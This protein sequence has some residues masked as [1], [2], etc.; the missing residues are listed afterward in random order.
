MSSLPFGNLSQVDVGGTPA[1]CAVLPPK[2]A[3]LLGLI[4]STASGSLDLRPPRPGFAAQNGHS[5]TP[6]TAASSSRLGAASSRL[7]A[8]VTTPATLLSRPQY[9]RNDG[10]APSTRSRK[11]SVDTSASAST[12]AG[13]F[14][15]TPNNANGLVGYATSAGQREFSSFDVTK[16]GGRPSLDT[17]ATSGE[18]PASLAHGRKMSSFSAS[19]IAS[20]AEGRGV[21]RKGPPSPFSYLRK[22]GMSSSP[23]LTAPVGNDT[24][25]TLAQ[26]KARA[27]EHYFGRHCG[28][29]AAGDEDE[30]ESLV[31]VVEPPI[32]YLDRRRKSEAA[33]TYRSSIRRED[34]S[35]AAAAGSSSRSRRRLHNPVSTLVRSLSGKSSNGNIGGGFLSRKLSRKA[36]KKDVRGAVPLVQGSTTTDAA[37][38]GAEPRLVKKPSIGAIEAAILVGLMTRQESMRTTNEGGTSGLTRKPSSRRKPAPPLPTPQPEPTPV[39]ERKMARRKTKDEWEMESAELTRRILYG[40]A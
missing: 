24:I 12:R 25:S 3:A 35:L 4:P 38:V 22:E 13:S 27:Q 21:R 39:V 32:G 2:A 40:G 10:W 33:V 15:S 28:G 16:N 31:D 19:L 30:R 9:L 23:N 20:Q 34:S 8:L 1:H 11:D 17:L 14:W 5:Y 6:S 18:P 29:G 37:A 7:P 26:L 36:S